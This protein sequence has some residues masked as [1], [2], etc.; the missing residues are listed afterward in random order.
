MSDKWGIN[1][2][3]I[4]MTD[5][6]YALKIQDILH[7]YSDYIYGR[8]GLPSKCARFFI[9]SVIFLGAEEKALEL[10]E[11]IKKEVPEVRVGISSL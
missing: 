4:A 7:R 8:I 5:N 2:I 9:I 10:V 3:T 6:A 11:T 1:T